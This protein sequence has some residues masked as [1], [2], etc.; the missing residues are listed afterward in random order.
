[1]KTFLNLK[2]NVTNLFPCFQPISLVCSLGAIL[3]ISRDSFGNNKLD[4]VL[5]D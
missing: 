3:N 4:M 2:T 5:Y 1:M